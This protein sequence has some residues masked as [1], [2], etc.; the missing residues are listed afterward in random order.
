MAEVVITNFAPVFPPSDGSNLFHTLEKELFP[1]KGCKAH[2]NRRTLYLVQVTQL[3]HRFRL[4]ATNETSCVAVAAGAAK[5]GIP[6]PAC[7]NP[8]S[9]AFNIAGQSTAV[10]SACTNRLETLKLVGNTL[11][12]SALIGRVTFT[13]DLLTSNLVR[14]IA[15]RVGNLRTNFGISGTFSS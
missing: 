9:Q 12:I 1:E 8:T 2:L 13:F 4:S 3:H 14:I 11:S 5:H 10:D 7:N 15:R 6:P